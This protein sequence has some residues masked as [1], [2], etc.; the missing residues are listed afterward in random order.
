MHPHL[1]TIRGRRKKIFLLICSGDEVDL[2]GINVLKYFFP[3]FEIV[4]TVRKYTKKFTTL[5]ESTFR[6]WVK[7]YKKN[8]KEKKKTNKE[9]ALKIAQTRGRPLSLDVGLDSKLRAMIISLRTAGAGIS[10]HVIRGILIGLVQSYYRMK[11]SRR[12]AT[13]SRPV[14]TRSL[15]NEI[16]SQFPHEISQK[17]LLHSIPDELIIN[18]DHT[19]SLLLR[20]IPWQPRDKSVFHEKHWSSEK[21]TVRLIEQVLVPYI[22]KFKEEK[23][24]PNNQKKSPY[25]G[26][27]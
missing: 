23:G 11:V 7:R 17:V 2:S 4:F 15:W 13:T 21:E 22:K 1:F 5:T 8:L 20:L 9:V 14:I 27:F 3:K 18:A 10:Q 12:V 19:L 25:M 16:K 24:L 26:C 6:P